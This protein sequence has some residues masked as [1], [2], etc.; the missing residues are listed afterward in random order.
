MKLRMVVLL[1][2]MLALAGW[3]S[4]QAAGAMPMVASPAGLKF[5]PLPSI[6]ACATGAG[7]HGDPMKGSFVLLIKATT[8]C[9]VPMHWHTANEQVGMVSGSGSL[10]MPKAKAQAMTAGAYV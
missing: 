10:M 2:M 8:G 3:A 1:T 4:A 9:T 7:L 6:P 5:G